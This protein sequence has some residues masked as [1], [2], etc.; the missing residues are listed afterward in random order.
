MF[1][2][3]VKNF[4]HK[5][6]SVKLLQSAV[7]KGGRMQVRQAFNLWKGRVGAS[8]VRVDLMKTVFKLHY[9]KTLKRAYIR[10]VGYMH[11]INHRVR[12]EQLTELWTRTRL[13]QGLFLGWREGIAAENR[14]KEEGVFRAWKQLSGTSQ[15][16]KYVERMTAMTNQVEKMKNKALLRKYFDY[17]RKNAKHELYSGIFTELMEKERPKML[18]VR[19]E[20]AEFGELDHRKKMTN[21]FR[22]LL[23]NFSNSLYSYFMQWKLEVG[24]YNDMMKRVKMLMIRSYKNKIGEAFVN[25]KRRGDMTRLYDMT[26]MVEKLGEE[27]HEKEKDKFSIQNML[28]EDNKREAVKRGRKAGD[29]LRKFGLRITRHRFN[30]WHFN[31]KRGEVLGDATFKI[32]G[33]LKKRILRETFAKYKDKVSRLRREE[34]LKNKLGRK[35]MGMDSQIKKRAFEGFV[36]FHQMSQRA[37]RY[38]NRMFVKG[39]RRLLTR[40]MNSWKAAMVNYDETMIMAEQDRIQ[41]EIDEIRRQQEMTDASILEGRR[42]QDLL[43][44]SMERMGQRTMMKYMNLLLNKQLAN[45]FYG[46]REASDQMRRQENLMNKYMLKLINHFQIGAFTKWKD[47]NHAER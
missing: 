38:F 11:D 17:I 26:I 16:D 36:L 18:Q 35:L 8:G 3:H 19:N 30:L 24:R 25:W 39:D 14:D 41:R 21:V 7:D 43:N 34:R 40:G 10:W 2:R 12:L 47:Y 44:E 13:L 45:G 32:C 46:W 15:Q 6:E 5:C 27:A 37:K 29:L 31:V 9:K 22:T 23:K 33:K 28:T 4:D 20:L 1:H 42:K